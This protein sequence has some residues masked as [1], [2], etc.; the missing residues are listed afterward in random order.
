MAKSSRSTPKKKG[1]QKKVTSIQPKLKQKQ[2][3]LHRLKALFR[4][5]NLFLF[6]AFIYAFYMVWT[7]PF[8]DV[9]NIEINGLSNIGYA[10]INKY[11]PEKSYKGLNILTLDPGKISKTLNNTRVFRAVNVYRSLFPTSLIINFEERIPFLTIHENSSD[12]D[13]TIDDEGIVLTYVNPNRE[14]ELFFPKSKNDNQNKNIKKN[15]EKNKNSV[16]ETK[17]DKGKAIY[18]INKAKDFSLNSEQLNCIRVIENLRK[19][20]KID[21][22]GVFDLTDPQNIILN[23][24][25]NKVLLGGLDELIMKIKSIPPLEDLSKNNKNELE[26]IDV[27]YWKNPVLKLKKGSDSYEKIKKEFHN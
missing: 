17:K 21:D 10:Y 20:K 24:T 23:T 26:Y 9:T 6:C 16:K 1:T 13:I 3:V 19:N 8:W 11:I 22:I 27:R 25:E 15:E 14:D 18:S 4:L 2:K 12:Q 7:L 5:I